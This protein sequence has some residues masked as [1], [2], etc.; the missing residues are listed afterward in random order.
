MSERGVVRDVRILQASARPL[1]TVAGRCAVRTAG[2]HSRAL[3]V[4]LLLSVVFFFTPQ[5]RAYYII[6]LVTLRVQFCMCVRVLFA[7]IALLSLEDASACG[8]GTFIYEKRN[9]EIQQRQN[10]SVNAEKLN[11]IV[12]SQP[13]EWCVVGS[14]QKLPY[15]VI[16]W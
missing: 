1:P 12:H 3:H 8:V 10:S 16:C 13:S 7:T 5:V 4:S 6:A 14:V 2:D 11:N 9:M 15:I